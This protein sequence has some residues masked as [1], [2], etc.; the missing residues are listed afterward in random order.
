MYLAYKDNNHIK[1]R[2]VR[3]LFEPEFDQKEIDKEGA[4][5]IPAPTTPRPIYEDSQPGA[6]AMEGNR[7]GQDDELTPAEI[8]HPMD[9]DVIPP[10]TPHG[11]D[12]EPVSAGTD[13]NMDDDVAH[14]FMDDDDDMGDPDGAD[15]PSAMVSALRAAGADATAAANA[16]RS[17]YGISDK[18][19]PSLIEAYGTAVHQHIQRRNL[20]VR[21][22]GSLDLRTLKANG[23]PWDFSK[24]SDRREAR[25]LISRTN[26]DWIIGSPPCTPYSIWNFGINYKKMDPARVQQILRDGDVH[27]H[28]VCSLYRSQLRKGKY[29]L[30]EHPATA[31][32]WKDSQIS[33]LSRDP[34]VKLV[35]ADQCEYGLVTPSADDP[36]VMV[37]AM[38]PTKFMTN[39]QAM[40]EQLCK[41]CQGNHDH[42]HLVGNRCA[43]AAFYPA[44]LVK[45][46][47]RGITLQ[48]VQDNQL[49]YIHAMPMRF[50][51]S[52]ASTGSESDYGQPSFSKVDKVGGGSIPV[53]YE[54]CNFKPQY[55][56]EYTGEPLDHKLLRAAMEDELN[57]FNEK[58]WRIT[59]VEEMQKI[60]DHI[61]TRSRW[62]LCNKGDA[63]SP[64]VRARLVACEINHGDKND[65][66]A[67]STPPLE[68]KRLLFAKY[69]SQKTSRNGSPL[70]LG[71]V[72]IRKAY[73]NAIPTR[74]IFMKIPKEMGLPPNA[75]AQQIRCVYGTRD[76]GK[77]W[78]DCY[79]QV[80]NSIGFLTGKSNPC[81]F[82]HPERDMSIVVHGDDFTTLANDTDMDW[83]EGELKK[84][85]E[86]KIRGRLGLG[87]PGP[88]EIKIL[89]RIVSVDESGLTYE[90]DPRHTDLLMSSL[91]LSSA[92]AS[93]TPGVK[94]TDRDEF[95]I[96]SDEGCNS[97]DPDA[98]IAAICRGG[99]LPGNGVNEPDAD[100]TCTESNERYL[101]HTMPAGLPTENKSIYLDSTA[102]VGSTGVAGCA[103]SENRPSTLSQ[104]DPHKSVFHS[105]KFDKARL[106]DHWLSSHGVH[107]LVHENRRLHLET[108]YKVACPVN[109]DSLCS[110]R[111]TRGIDSDGRQFSHIDN[112]RCE[113]KAHEKLK[114]TWRGTTTYFDN[115][116]ADVDACISKLC[117]VR[118]G[119]Q[120]GAGADVHMKRANGHLR[121][122]FSTQVETYDCTPYSEMYDA[123]PHFLLS[124]RDGWKKNPARADVFTGKTSL[125]MRERRKSA[126]RRFSAASAKKTRKAILELANMQMQEVQTITDDYTTGT[127]GLRHD[128]Y[129]MDTDMI[130]VAGAS[131]NVDV[132]MQT[133]SMDTVPMD[134]SMAAEPLTS[135]RVCATRTKPVNNAKY[136]KRVGAKKAKKLELDKN[137]EFVLS[138]ADAT[139][140]RALAARCNY[141]SQD[142]PDISFASKELCREFS[143]PN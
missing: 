31:M 17:M 131:D 61:V 126:R 141:L 7:V 121:V 84:S 114:Y 72:D 26:P 55:T 8:E 52:K 43:A 53:K 13:A 76:A 25:E 58:V 132:G 138:Q 59:T 92:N 95:A 89:N 50:G 30:H 33:A 29:F 91:N 71:F 41:R 15:N 87:C 3:H 74:Q 56:D 21:G 122:Q 97:L 32:S 134:I 102:S 19:S 83:Y 88:Q 22:L 82:Y 35:T 118:L 14:L 79:T 98:V 85:F 6:R 116:C 23:E 11:A 110:V 86:I 9:T 117:A 73:F 60:P 70:R 63:E 128:V 103:S 57:Y 77:L 45:A 2:N 42:Q 44:P 109:P 127:T 106:S 66:F 28:F 101:D 137:S 96:K 108:P 81:T 12:D 123:H 124:T 24:R 94:P 99:P 37:P 5:S 142:R 4:K 69:V 18:S 100:G 140:Y 36:N 133:Q 51:K 112:W 80:L 34:L 78:E 27:L 136:A 93:A 49:G 20:N 111:L 46:M 62:V 120:H 129:H 113:Q 143:I 39:S 119:Q 67:A 54:A 125:V 47:L 135:G 38:K 90:A 65:M 64:D 1:Y 68:A 115:N 105:T 104:N 16:A 107:T 40:A 75:V 48:A 139:T 10:P 130:H